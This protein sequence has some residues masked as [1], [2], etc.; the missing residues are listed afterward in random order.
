LKPEPTQEART[1]SQPHSY[2]FEPDYQ[3]SF[4]PY[5]T[6]PQTGSTQDYSR[7]IAQ[8]M[9][10]MNLNQQIF[11]TRVNNEFEN[12]NNE[13]STLKGNLTHMED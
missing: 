12:I 2:T 11:Q 8:S 5:L 6:P 13:I 4:D 9:S 1:F 10:Y 7:Y 3:T